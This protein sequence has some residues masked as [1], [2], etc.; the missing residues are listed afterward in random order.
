MNSRRIMSVAFVALLLV[1]VGA[2]VLLSPNAETASAETSVSDFAAFSQ[3]AN[4]SPGE[5]KERGEV[6]AW[7]EDS[8]PKSDFA[9][10]KLDDLRPVELPN[11]MGRIWLA[12]TTDE[13]LAIFVPTVDSWAYARAS[14]S[15]LSD[16]GAVVMS[17]VGGV[18]SA[19][20]LAVVVGAS[21]IAT[22]QIVKSGSEGGDAEKVPLVNNVATAVLDPG[23]SIVSGS[24]KLTAPKGSITDELDAAVRAQAAAEA[25]K[26]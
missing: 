17:R 5:S 2:A 7:A 20:S 9:G 10:V 25:A 4:L 16:D 12:R 26:K 8:V 11:E 6:F 21:S 19:N 15:Q 3:A 1:A 13:G 22:P 18:E 23:D 24:T 14:W